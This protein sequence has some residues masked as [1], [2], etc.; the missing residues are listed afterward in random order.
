[1]A[2]AAQKDVAK[3]GKTE[4]AI[5]IAALELLL[6]VVG[7]VATLPTAF[8]VAFV[9]IVYVFTASFFSGSNQ[10][11]LSFVQRTPKDRISDIE[12]LVVEETIKNEGS[13]PLFLEILTSLP[14]ELVVNQGSNHYIVYLRGKE[15]RRIRY[16]TRPLFPGHFMIPSAKIRTMNFFLA[17]LDEK[18]ERS[19][20][21]VSAYPVLEELRRFPTGRISMRPLH[22]IIPSR[23]PGLGTEFFEIREYSSTD[24]FRRINWKASARTGTLLSNEYELERIADI[25]VIIDSTASTTLFLKDYIR[26]CITISDYFLRMGNRVGL[27][28][29]GRASCRER[30]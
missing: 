5:A 30:V 11:K 27:V 12:D 17:S 23:S 19:E 13:R 10:L 29:I 8:L 28:E 25:Y 26:V 14:D 15:T 16:Q 20:T 2:S 3:K 9:V 22:G 4:K 6:I 1:M 24:D 7:F 21:T 18:I